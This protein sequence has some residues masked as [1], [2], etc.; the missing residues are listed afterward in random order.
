M[1]NSTGA[2]LDLTTV[3]DDTEPS[4]DSKRRSHTPRLALVVLWCEAEPWRAGEVLRVPTGSGVWLLGRG[5]RGGEDE[6]QRLTFCQQRPGRDISTAPLMDRKISRRQLR[7]SASSK[8]PDRLDVENVG[9]RPMLI[10]GTRTHVGSLGPGS[11]LEVHKRLLLLCQLRDELSGPRSTHPFGEADEFG[12]VG[13][14]AAMWRLRERIAFIGARAGHVLILGESGTGKE[15]IAG[16]I[17]AAS[18]RAG[19]RMIA[20]N[21]ATIPEGLVDAELFGNTRDYPNAGMPARP[22]LIGAAN[23]TTLFLDEIAELPI[24]QQSH[25]LRVLDQD[26]EYH[27]LGEFEA[28]YSDLRLI[29]ATNRS[30][31]KLRH[32]FVMRLPLRIESP[33]L[34]A[35]REDIPLLII[36]LL[37][38]IAEKDP[39]I[40]ARFMVAA[41][42]PR[43]RAFPLIDMALIAA[44][45]HHEYTH[46]V[47]E[48]SR[49][50][51]ISL[52]SS[53][54]DRLALT[55]EVEAEIRRPRPK[56][57]P[58][59][60][61]PERIQACLDRHAGVKAHVWRELGLSNRFALRRLI[62]K[63]NLREHPDTPTDDAK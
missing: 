40:N 32:D 39:L 24:E 47:R 43:G 36:Q 63:H 55:E 51:W 17:H 57:E 52:A 44:L 12:V 8:T 59:S 20:R 53:P 42:E 46:H 21:A 23:N 19:A 37:E 18:P 4:S 16:A 54:G 2:G 25:L 58:E 30:V 56:P 34:D 27:R 14:S 11:M 26:G 10:N 3:G 60:L 33:N 45:T 50:L 7:V 62:K 35:R 13:E 61:T 31:E 28:R 1:K 9:R 38:K 6:A 49:L 15:L 41:A 5:H 48:I 22:G 29:A